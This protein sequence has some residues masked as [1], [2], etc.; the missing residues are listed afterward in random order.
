MMY[1]SYKKKD[2]Q[3]YGEELRTDLFSNQYP[4]TTSGSTGQPVKVYLS[5]Y[6][7]IYR[8]AVFMRFLNWWDC[9]IFDKNVYIWGTKGLVKNNKFRKKIKKFLNGRLDINVFNLNDTTILS[10]FNKI[11]KHNPQFIR[12]YK[13]AILLLAEL[14]ETHDL[15]FK[16]TKLKV[17]I[18]TSEVLYE[19]ERNYMEKILN[20]SV[21]NEYGASEAGGIIAVECR[22]GNM[23]INEETIYLKQ[24]NQNNVLL[25]E[26]WN[27]SMPLLNYKLG[28][29]VYLSEKKCECGRDLKV[30]TKI[31][32]R[33]NDY[34]IKPN[35]QKLSQYT[36]YYLFEEIRMQGFDTAIRKYNVVQKGDSFE[37]K[38][39]TGVG[40]NEDIKSLIRQKMK[41][42]IGEDISII[43]TKVNQIPREKSGK[44]RFFKRIK[45]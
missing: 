44:L 24:D 36:F 11:E 2:I 33:E 1:P 19:A 32:G 5:K 4:H 3:K 13:S 45:N 38:I 6:A 30:I 17:A 12:G 28:D 41:S 37:I 25:T 23:H 40:F 16:L 7:S 8:Q 20:C 21:A 29:K 27:D 39:E 18:V 31:E 43:I 42:K 9:N 14:M 15:R 26:V 35:G 22:D 34:I 10:Y